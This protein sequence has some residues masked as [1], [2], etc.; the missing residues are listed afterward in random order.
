MHVLSKLLASLGF[1]F[2][3]VGLIALPVNKLYADPGSGQ[4]NQG[5]SSPCNSGCISHEAS[6]CGDTGVGCR[7]N[8]DPQNC[9][10]CTCKLQIRYQ[11]GQE[12]GRDCACK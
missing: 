6:N 3:L 4:C 11:K 7:V 8:E 12:V 5:G 9:S 2:I 1:T 10:A